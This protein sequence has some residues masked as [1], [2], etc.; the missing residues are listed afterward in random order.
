MFHSKHLDEKLAHQTFGTQEFLELT[1]MFHSKHPDEKLAH[2]TFGTQ[3]SLLA[4]NHG[5]FKN[6]H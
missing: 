2:Q 4:S 6:T 5:P 3:E 1:I